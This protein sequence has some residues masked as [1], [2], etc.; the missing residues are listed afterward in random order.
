EY[1]QHNYPDI[2][3]LNSKEQYILWLSLLCSKRYTK[4]IDEKEVYNLCSQYVK[5][6][7]NMKERNERA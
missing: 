1:V 4:S 2:G 3:Y 5:D 6:V 7:M